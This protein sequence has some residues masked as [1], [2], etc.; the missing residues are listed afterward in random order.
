[1]AETLD[2]LRLLIRSRHPVV[3]IE[4]HE[5]RRAVARVRQ[6]AE[7]F[8]YSC[9]VWNLVDGMQELTRTGAKIPH[10]G[11]PA[12][13]LASIGAQSWPA[14]YILEDFCPH[15]KDPMIQRLFR[16]LAE[17]ASSRLQ[18]VVLIDAAT[19]LP[20]SLSRLAVPFTFRLPNEAEL[21][22]VVRE[23]FKEH[24]RYLKIHSELNQ[25]QFS[26]LVWMLR[27]LTAEEA[28][29]AVSRVILDD[30][31]LN[32]DDIPR[33]LS[34]KRELVD[35][36]GVLDYI[37]PAG[38]LDSIGGLDR[39][40][41]WLIKR[42]GAMTPQAHDFGL[43]PPRG[44]LLLGVQ[45]CGKSAACKAV[46]AA[47]HLPLLR[48]DPACLYDKFVGESEKHLRKAIQQAEAMAPIVLWI[49]EIEKAFASAGAESADGGLSKRMFGT[50]LSWLQDH[51]SPIFCA[52]TANDISAL[53]PE[54]IRKGRFDEIFFV[55]L[56][57]R[58]VRQRI[59]TI[60]LL[61][62]K[63]LPEQFDV[64]ALADASEGFS[65]AEIEQVVISALY[66]AFGAHRDL[67]QADILNE[68]HDSRPLS[69]TMAE[70]V[71]AL[72]AWAADRCVPA[73]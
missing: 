23:T 48:L 9:Y 27:G 69:V 42:A 25:H 1:M 56:P 21:E 5:E 34:I 15:L 50:L 4:T 37:E 46:A 72:R 66:A 30:D 73:D 6:A 29:L 8:S 52:A 41:K 61:K 14:V 63:R 36:G 47:W 22:T 10:T 68:L 35:K 40:K 54:L 65:G 3:T 60:H 18:T 57:N 55:D 13:V 12:E 17:N 49:D 24:A 38:D 7:S 39:L 31:C 71:A 16:G 11:K 64:A 70:R 51:K 58:E 43:D 26:H 62:R 67:T 19:D 59:L 44:I 20:E 45:G 2:D 33:L 28:K 32:A 53:P